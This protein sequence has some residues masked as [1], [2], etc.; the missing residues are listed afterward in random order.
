MGKFVFLYAGGQSADTPEAQKAA[1]EAWMGWFGTLGDDVVD[2]GNPFGASSTVSADGSSKD[3]A[4]GGMGGYSVISANTLSEAA[5]KAKGCP[6]L[7]GGGTV[8]VYEALAV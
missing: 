2:I 4:A 6:V 3:G 8:E 5:S 1:M 7:A